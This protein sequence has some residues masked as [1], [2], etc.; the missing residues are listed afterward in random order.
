M[1]WIFCCRHNATI[2][3]CVTLFLFTL[4]L[5]KTVLVIESL[6]SSIS[7]MGGKTIKTL[8]AVFFDIMSS[9]CIYE[10]SGFYERG[11]AWDPWDPWDGLA[12]FDLWPPY[13]ELAPL[14]IS[15]TGHCFGR[16]IC[17]LLAHLSVVVHCFGRLLCQFSV[18]AFTLRCRLV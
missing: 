4:S 7:G 11:M 12:L 17:G 18:L 9:Q 8:Q 16:H 1:F 10:S 15:W 5:C 2:L 6:I 13:L 3:N 14:R